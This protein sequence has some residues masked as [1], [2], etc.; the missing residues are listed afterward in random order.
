MKMYVINFFNFIFQSPQLTLRNL[1][2]EDRGVYRCIADNDVRPPATHDITL[3][4]EFR[5]FARA[6]QTSYG[7]AQNRMFDLTIEC[8]IAG[9][10]SFV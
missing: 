10:S 3:F 6:V 2:R 7:Q 9:K 1:T 4:V 5:P 8:R